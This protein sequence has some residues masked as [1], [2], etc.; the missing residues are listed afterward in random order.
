MA[1]SIV[2][3]NSAKRGFRK[4]PKE[5]QRRI[6]VTID[7]LTEEPRPEGTEKIEGA[8]GNVYRL[9]VGG[10]RILYEIYDDLII[11]EIIAI[12]VRGQIYRLIK[13]LKL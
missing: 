10:Y 4:I 6:A 2:F 5:F 11:V 3:R 13:Q 12:G 9:R 7:A 1:Y 8:G